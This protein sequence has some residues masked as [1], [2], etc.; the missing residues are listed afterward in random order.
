VRVRD[1]GGIER[2]AEAMAV[3]GELFG[4]NRP[5][6]NTVV[7]NRLLRPQAL[8][9]I[10]SRRSP[11]NRRCVRGQAVI[12]GPIVGVIVGFALNRFSRG[13]HFHRCW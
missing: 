13:A 3:R 12:A 8:I 2:Y 4:V 9:E 6:V 10:E 5:A 1:P 7:V 11:P